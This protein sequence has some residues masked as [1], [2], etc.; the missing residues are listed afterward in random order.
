MDLVLRDT[1]NELRAFLQD[2]KQRAAEEDEE[3]AEQAD[4]RFMALSIDRACMFIYAFLS[5]VLPVSMY[6]SI[7]V[8]DQSYRIR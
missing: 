8:Q 1:L 4:W 6:L 2:S 3:E 7:P 5:I